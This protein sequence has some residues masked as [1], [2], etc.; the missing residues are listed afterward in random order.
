MVGKG[1]GTVGPVVSSGGGSLAVHAA[2]VERELLIL[3]AV[4]KRADRTAEMARRHV[5]QVRTILTRMRTLAS[6]LVAP[7]PVPWWRRVLARLA[8]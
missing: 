7:P 4:S 1:S 2:L 8:L 5:E 6:V 3:D